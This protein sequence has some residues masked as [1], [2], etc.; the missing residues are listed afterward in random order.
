[1]NTIVI[2][3]GTRQRIKAAGQIAGVLAG[4]TALS[5]GLLMRQA[6]DARRIIPLAEAPPPRGDGVYGA[7][8]PGRPLNLV[9][10]GDSS[11]AG[12]GVH[13]PRETPGALF[14]TGI[15]R[16]LHRPVRLHRLAVVGSVSAGLPW[17]VDAALDYQP[18]L[19]IILIGG[20]DVTHFSA[21]AS[22]VTHLGDAVRRLREAGCRVVVGTCPDIGA[23]QPIKPPLRWL[24]RRWSR[25]L[26]AAQTVAVV[27]AGGRTVSIG[28][29]LGPMFEADPARM[30]GSDRFHPS[31]EGYARAAAVM[32]PTVMA[33]LG[34]D[35]RPAVPLAETVRTLPEA[36]DEAVRAPGTEVSPVRAGG[37]WAQ[38][39]R[40]PWFGE[41]RHWFGSGSKPGAASA[42]G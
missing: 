4:L 14:A 42:V 17:Q 6:A 9:I 10:L 12:Y 1:M 13:R 35:D 11:A 22:A 23:I 20:N 40:H 37:R 7:K 8:F 21:R 24:A 36:A 2:S 31:A 32:M 26:A 25:Q 5:A 28:N 3:T 15:S 41:S 27:R 30:F 18:D 34:E 19:A 29:L 38:L 16:R 33:A 39:R